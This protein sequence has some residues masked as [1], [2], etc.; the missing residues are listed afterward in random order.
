MEILA[1]HGAVWGLLIVMG[2]FGVL[3]CGVCVFV[4]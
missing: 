2:V 3:S 1:A 4:S